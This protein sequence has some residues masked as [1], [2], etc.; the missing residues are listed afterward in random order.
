[1]LVN[2]LTFSKMGCLRYI[3]E[4]AMRSD[5]RKLLEKA[6]AGSDCAFEKLIRKYD[7]KI[8][9]VI[10]SLV[11]DA[12]DVRDLYQETFL[13]VYRSLPTFRYESDFYTWIYRI[14]VNLCL[15]HLRSRKRHPVVLD[16]PLDDGRILPNVPARSTP[17]DDL[18][19]KELGTA[20]ADALI[21]LS[22]RQ[23]IVFT[24][25]HYEGRKLKEIADMI[26]CSENAAKNALFR[27]TQKL[28]KLLAEY[29]E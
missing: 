10:C 25:K 29:R 14:A 23:R 17:E 1:M 13:R 5:D 28:R 26:G 18:M 24:L 20:I 3:E 9:Q 15:N 22:P 7:R 12:E 6:Q 11:G 8:T 16:S 19:N 21:T 4:G 27:A 2:V